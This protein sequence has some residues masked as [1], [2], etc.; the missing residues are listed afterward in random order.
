M[1]EEQK[2]TK[3]KS[4]TSSKKSLKAAD[5]KKKDKSVSKKSSVNGSKKP[6]PN[7]SHDE[8][9]GERQPEEVPLS[10]EPEPRF[11]AYPE[12]HKITRTTPER[13]CVHHNQSLKFY[14]EACEEPICEE[15]QYS[16]PHNTELHR[17][18]TLQE[19]FNA[20]CNYLREGTYAMLLE[21]RDKLLAQL[22]KLDYRIAEIKSV[23]GIIE[24]DIKTEYFGMLERLNSAEGMKYAVLQHDMAEVQKD[25][26]RIDT[27]FDSLDE[28]LQGESRGDYVGF[29]IKFRELHEYIEYAVTKQ[30]KTKVDVPVNDLP[31]ELTERRKVLEHAEKVESLL[32]FKDEIIWN[33]IQEKKKL[34]KTAEI[35]LDK[36]VQQEWAEWAKL[37]ERY[38]EELLKYK[39]VCSFCGV[40]LDDLSVNS[41]CPGKTG[42]I[43]Y[44]AEE[45]PL[46]WKE[47]RRHYFAKP[48]KEAESKSFLSK[49]MEDPRALS[50]FNTIKESEKEKIEELKRRLQDADKEGIYEVS[51]SDFKTAVTDIYSIDEVKVGFLTEVL[52]GGLRNQVQY[53]ELLQHIERRA[54]PLV[55]HKMPELR[56]GPWKRIVE[57]MK[58]NGIGKNDMIERFENYDEERKGIV[59]TDS[60][61]LVFMKI[62]FPTSTT[63]IDNLAKLDDSDAAKAGQVNYID[64]LNKIFP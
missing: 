6:S 3:K 49:V 51:Q 41:V 47:G 2:L 43:Q 39:L 54:E 30:F 5:P 45:P 13:L 36:A 17:V 26:E 42:G 9:L 34:T 7:V 12:A 33:L 58:K 53:K 22:D 20:R 61:Y 27:I 19:A 63:D 4:T 25:I 23:A 16:G 18:A 35:D 10:R 1:S 57:D 62:G 8:L 29:L 64:L 15:C 38:S 59:S 52:L 24:R 46:G 48:I 28:Y 11:P 55:R 56:D 31:R 21:K 44:T 32:K 50:V 60:F 40:A 14:C 37:I